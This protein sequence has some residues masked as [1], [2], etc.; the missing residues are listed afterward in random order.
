M[1]RKKIKIELVGEMDPGPGEFSRAWVT[2][3]V[4]K[5]L[6]LTPNKDWVYFSKDFV[7]VLS[8][9]GLVEGVVE[10]SGLKIWISPDRFQGT[11]IVPGDTL[12]TWK[13]DE[14]I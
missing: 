8:S 6:D 13:V 11:R 4:I 1:A 7:G 3:D 2:P 10:E 9:K 5:E 14:W 12:L